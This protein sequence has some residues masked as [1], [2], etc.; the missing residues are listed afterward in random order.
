MAIDLVLKNGKTLGIDVGDRTLEGKA[1]YI[2]LRNSGFVYTVDYTW[3][4]V[5]E[6]L[7]LDPPYPESKEK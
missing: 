6:R 4:E 3:Y 1:Y 5:L 7:V 2:K